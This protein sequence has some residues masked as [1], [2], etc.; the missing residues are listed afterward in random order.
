MILAMLAL[1]IATVLYGGATT[2]QAGCNDAL[3]SLSPCLN[4]LNGGS[5][6]PSSNC[7]SQFSTVVQSSPECLCYV[8]NSNESSFSGF[9]FNRTL[10]LNL[11][12]AC[13]VQTP[14]PSQ[15]NTGSNRPSTSP[16]NTPVGSPQSAPSPSGSKK[17]P[18]SSNESSSKRNVI[19]LSLVSIALVLA[20]I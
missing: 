17:F 6:S 1:V 8:V 13:N 18:W 4:Y 11:P 20:K 19:V 15:C 10:A 7:C 16:A 5:T 9:K 3:T 14:S 2:V 12:T